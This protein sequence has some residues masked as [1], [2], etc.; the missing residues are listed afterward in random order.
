MTEVLGSLKAPGE[1]QLKGASVELHI[2]PSDK[3][4][5]DLPEFASLE[6]REDLRRTKL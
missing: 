6:R 1:T 4:L 3:K 2:I 5:T